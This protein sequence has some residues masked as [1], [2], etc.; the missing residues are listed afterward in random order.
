MN[1]LIFLAD[2]ILVVHL[3]YVAL[4]VLG[5]PLIFIG[6][7]KRWTWV[8]RPW[9]RLLHLFMIG[10]VVAEVGL[11]WDCPLTIWERDC[12]IAGGEWEPRELPV[13]MRQENETHRLEPTR[14]Y[15]ENF[16]ARVL[17]SILFI[18]VSVL[19]PQ[20]L[21]GIYVAIGLVVAGLW[22]LVPPTRSPRPSSNRKT[23]S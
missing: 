18:D 4:V 7:W 19:S 12:R 3:L 14:L 22:W 15:Q 5:I 21:Q 2:C 23:A 11:G 6:W 1:W 10:I 8:R 20:V 17:H 13:W 9:I 16:L